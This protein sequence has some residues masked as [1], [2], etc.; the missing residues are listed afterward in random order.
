MEIVTPEVFC[1][2]ETTLHHADVQGYLTSIGAA[3][4]NTNADYDAEGLVEIAGR[5]CY[6]SFGTELNPNLTMVRNDNKGYVDN[7]LKSKHGSVLEHASVTY[8]I[9]NVSRI[10]THEMV[11]HRHASPSQESMR[12]VRLTELKAYWPDAFDKLPEPH[13]EEVL[14]IFT[15]TF[16]RAEQ[17][18]L[19]LAAKLDMDGDTFSFAEKKKLQSA[20][21]RL[22]PDGICTGIIIS[23]NHRS[24]REMIL[25]RTSRHA[26]E[27]I[28]KVF[29]IIALDLQKRVPAV[30]QDMETELVDGILECTFKHGV[31]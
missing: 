6:K 17:T 7:V 2:A 29:E 19:A 23:A 13:R 24:W 15:E 26:E 28:R 11:R 14:S 18:Q 12:F 10:F 25:K 8:A 27:E 22:I 1:L 3:R 31:A 20:M 30:Y 21:R 4:W 16:V 9:E 5:R